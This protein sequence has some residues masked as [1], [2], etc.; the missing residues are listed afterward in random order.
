MDGLLH[1]PSEGLP[2]QYRLI[3]ISIKQSKILRPHYQEVPTLIQE[4]YKR[5]AEGPGEQAFSDYLA[6]IHQQ[7]EYVHPFHDGNGRMGR[8]ILNVLALQ[9]GYPVI[10]F[11]PELCG[12]FSNAVEESHEGNLGLFTRMLQE[13]FYSALCL[14]QEAIGQQLLPAGAVC[15]NNST[16]NDNSSSSNNI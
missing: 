15:G 4:V 2:G 16:S 13:A 3:N 8:L 6:G 10:V 9:R 7:F 14:Y 11:P 12:I 1:D 5:I